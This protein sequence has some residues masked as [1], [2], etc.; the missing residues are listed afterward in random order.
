MTKKKIILYGHLKDKYPHSIEVEA[1]TV[2]EAVRSLSTID[3]L[4]PP[5]GEPWPVLVQGVDSE[6][7]L[8]SETSLDEIH[9]HPRV[10][11][12]KNGGILQI[13]LGIA[14]IGL[15]FAT[16]GIAALGLSKGAMI[17]AGGLMV[18]GGILQMMMPTPQGAEESESSKYLGA[19]GN[20]VKIGTRIPLAYGNNRLAGHYLSFDVDAF[21]WAGDGAIPVISGLGKGGGSSGGPSQGEIIGDSVYVE[22]DKTPIPIAPINPVYASPEAAPSN[23]PTSGWHG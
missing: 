6:I 5:N 13:F 1:S 18:L 16:G 2:A 12:A 8:F 17:L 7:A 11:G 14:L 21:D 4:Q 23:L 10:G 22:H 3:E 20:T 15:A 9:I 19:T